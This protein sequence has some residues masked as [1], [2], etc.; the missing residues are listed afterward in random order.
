MNLDHDFVQMRKFSED[1]RKI[2]TEHFFPRIQ[3][4]TKKKKV[5]F[6]NRTFFLP[7][8]RWRAKK[9]KVFF[10]NRTP[11]FPNFSWSAKKKVFSKNRTLFFP[12]F[13]LSCTPILIIGWDGDVDHSQTIGRDT[14]KLLGRIY[15]P[16]PPPPPRVSAPLSTASASTSLVTT[17]S[18][19]A[20]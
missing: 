8:F 19:A 6:R 13:T 15:P 20:F 7:D 17:L 14:A 9:K 12:K 18:N 11:F 4:K 10:R 2:Q 5:F 1:K 3:V 16:I